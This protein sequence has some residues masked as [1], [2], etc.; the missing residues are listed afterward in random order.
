MGK[1]KRDIADENDAIRVQKIDEE[2]II[3]HKE[4]T[5]SPQ[6]TAESP[7]KKKKSH[8]K[9]VEMEVN[10]QTPEDQVIAEDTPNTKKKKRKHRDKTPDLESSRGILDQPTVPTENHK[11]KRKKHKHKRKDIA[12]S[13][14]ISQYDD[15]PLELEDHH[16][17]KKKKHKH[18]KKPSENIPSKTQSVDSEG[19]NLT[20]QKSHRHK[21]KEA[22]TSEST[23]QYDDHS[24]ELEDHRK[25]KRKKHKHKTE[26]SENITSKTQEIDNEGAI[27]HKK[28]SHQHK[29]KKVDT[30]ES[31]IQNNDR[32]VESEETQEHH[33]K[34]KRKKH[35][36]EKEF[37][38]N[39]RSETQDVDNEGEKHTKKKS[40]KQKEKIEMSTS[41]LE[42][43][44]EAA[45]NQY[46]QEKRK[47]HKHKKELELVEA[48][49][50]TPEVIS[51]DVQTFKKRKR[52]EKEK[53]EETTVSEDVNEVQGEE[54]VVVPKK[55]KKRKQDKGEVL[56]DEE[57]EILEEKN[58]N[59]E[60]EKSARENNS[61][62]RPGDGCKAGDSSDTDE[63]TKQ[64]L[65]QEWQDRT[66]L[67]KLR[68]QQPKMFLIDNF[69]NDEDPRMTFKPV[70]MKDLQDFIQYSVMGNAANVNKIRFCKLVRPLLVSKVM[71]VVLNGV[72]D[73]CYQENREWFPHLNGKYDLMGQILHPPSQPQQSILN[74]LLQVAISNKQLK[75]RAYH[76]KIEGQTSKGGQTVVTPSAVALPARTTPS[77][78]HGRTHYLLNDEEKAK[79]RYPQADDP[80]YTHTEH[81]DTV[82]DKSPIVSVD[83]EMCVTKKGNELTRV[84]LVDEQYTVL[85]NSLVKP[86]NPI[87]DYVTRYSGITKELL[88]PVTVR[89][90]DVQK[91]IIALL[92]KDV[93]LVGQSLEND[94]RALRLFHPHVADT[95]NL[96]TGTYRVALRKLA[97]KYLGVTIQAKESGHDSIEDARVAMK[98]L[99]LKIEK[100][101]D[102]EKYTSNGSRKQAPEIIPTES[103]FRCA[104]SQSKVSML[105]DSLSV[106]RQFMKDPVGAIPCQTDSEALKKAVQAVPHSDFICVQFYNFAKLAQGISL[107]ETVVQETL[108][109]LDQRIK[110]I[111]KALPFNSF[112]LVVMATDPN[113]SGN[114]SNS[115]NDQV[116]NGRFF[117]GIKVKY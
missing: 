47:K 71:V 45:V 53:T 62:E 28:K 9:H 102:L 2:A 68:M 20:E 58:E 105:I 107:E 75:K 18:K 84:S 103:M 92:P 85:Y 48:V 59:G 46:H 86:H 5:D 83:C 7:R 91:D 69:T 74:Q 90:E 88:D 55:K 54:T 70:E 65:K 22:E 113:S 4:R 104:Q 73:A 24:L 33:H 14:S 60:K 100:G 106:A 41:N 49:D 79:W 15:C 110:K 26:S 35:K 98:L 112:F 17:E 31:T 95:S 82:S 40:H 76:A 78:A 6:Q 38:R 12:R 51:E 43:E 29:N 37:S 87:I 61:A 115:V 10:G 80:E 111:Y 94:L 21:E 34:E 39:S 27:C 108:K 1:R 101:S 114:R 44:Q 64:K 23:T 11:M 32:F 89:L 36:K 19:E 13:E 30:Q 50:E 96:F 77:T 116:T 16:K 42:I 109:Q 99:Q 97:W 8:K 52:K 63:E 117:T 72:T 67:K 3:Q 66:S 93:I 25:E 81:S 56:V 57:S